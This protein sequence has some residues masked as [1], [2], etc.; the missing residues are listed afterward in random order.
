M[1]HVAEVVHPV[2]GADA[3]APL[4]ALKRDAAVAKAEQVLAGHRW[5]PEYLR[6]QPEADKAVAG[7][8]DADYGSRATAAMEAST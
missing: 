4:A 2:A 7:G 3:A 1:A 8:P 6:T 5:L